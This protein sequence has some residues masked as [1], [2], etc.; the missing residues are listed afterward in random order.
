MTKIPLLRLHICLMNSKENN[1]ISALMQKLVYKIKHHFNYERPL[2]HVKH[3]SIENDFVLLG[4][5]LVV[6]ILVYT[7]YL[8]IFLT[9]ENLCLCYINCKNL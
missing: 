1:I 7:V 5:K 4:K 6:I 9:L 3:L 8:Q 2:K